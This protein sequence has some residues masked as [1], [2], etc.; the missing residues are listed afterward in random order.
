MKVIK[1]E[2]NSP[3]GLINLSYVDIGKFRFAAAK[4]ESIWYDKNKSRKIPIWLDKKGLYIYKLSFMVCYTPQFRNVKAMEKLFLKKT[5]DGDYLSIGHNED[6]EK[7]GIKSY[8][9]ELRN[10][11]GKEEI[12]EP[13]IYF[14]TKFEALKEGNRISTKYNITLDEY[15]NEWS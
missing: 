8:F 10:S 12:G 7:E 6:Y 11:E 14:S 15:I 9:I 13:L 2:K 5:D 3:D 4:S 1:Y